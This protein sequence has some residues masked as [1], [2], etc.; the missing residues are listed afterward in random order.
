M[1]IL[2]CSRTTVLLRCLSC[3][4]EHRHLVPQQR[5]ISSRVRVSCNHR[6][7]WGIRGSTMRLSELLS[8]V[9]LAALAHGS[10]GAG[11]GSKSA[12]VWDRRVFNDRRHHQHQ[13]RSAVSFIGRRPRT[14]TSRV[15]G[16]SEAES[17]VDPL[18]DASAAGAKGVRGS[19]AAAASSADTAAGD[20][21]AAPRYART[22]HTPTTTAVRFSSPTHP[23]H[24]MLY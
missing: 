3:V 24:V 20:S 11:W 17:A 1:G 19:P 10:R 9:N 4:F 23:L 8:V 2:H 12:A 15:T 22:Q 18:P 14:T 16:S 7:C 21:A 5:R 6:S 13:S